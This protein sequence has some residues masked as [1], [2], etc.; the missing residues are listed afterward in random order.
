MSD[1]GLSGLLDAL[2]LFV[3]QV[4]REDFQEWEM[5]SLDGF[6][7]AEAKSNPEGVF[8]LVGL[9]ILIS[10]Q[11]AR[12]TSSPARGLQAIRETGLLLPMTPA[13]SKPV[14]RYDGRGPVSRRHSIGSP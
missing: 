12:R 14:R 11:T 6:L 13:P 3:P 4:L 9:A 10:D 7:V 2:E 1:T 8:S 5:E